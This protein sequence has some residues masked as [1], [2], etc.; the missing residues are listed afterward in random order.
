MSGTTQKS[1]IEVIGTKTLNGSSNR[2]MIN[3]VNKS[4]GGRGIKRLRS[5]SPR[6]GR[7]KSPPIKRIGSTTIPRMLITTDRDAYKRRILITNIPYD[8]KWDDLKKFVNDQINEDPFVCVFH[9]TQGK[10]KGMAV[11]EFKS[12]DVVP[13]AVKQLNK[14]NFKGRDINVREET[15]EARDELGQPRKM[16]Q[17]TQQQ[18][19]NNQMMN[20]N[21]MNSNM[22]DSNFA[23]NQT[24]GIVP[25]LLAT[26]EIQPPL[27]RRV[28][29]ANLDYNVTEKEL[30]EGFSLAGR[31]V[32]IEILKS[33]EGKSRGQA[34]LEYSHPV[35]AVQAISMFRG[36]QFCGRE[37]S[38]RMDDRKTD[39]VL[40]KP[41][42]TVEKLPSQ[43]T[44]V[45]MGLGDSGR[46]LDYP[47]QLMDMA[48][49]TYV[50][51][52]SNTGNM[53]NQTQ[54]NMVASTNQAVAMQPTAGGV[55]TFMPMSTSFVPSQITQQQVNAQAI[56]QQQQPAAAPQQQQFINTAQNMITTP[57]AMSGGTAG[58]L[59]RN[60]SQNAQIANTVSQ[61]EQ[62][63]LMG[64]QQTGQQMVMGAD[65]NSV[66]QTGVAAVPQYNM[67][68]A[69]SSMPQMMLTSQAGNIQTTNSFTD[70]QNT[71]MPQQQQQSQQNQLQQQQQ[72]MMNNS[73][74]MYSEGGW[75][76]SAQ[77]NEMQGSGMMQMGGANSAGF[78][79]FVKNLPFNTS[80]NS[81]LEH[82]AGYIGNDSI[83][84]I[85]ML[86]NGS[87][88]VVKV[89]TQKAMKY[90]LDNI[91]GTM[92]FKRRMD[93][94]IDKTME[95]FASGGGY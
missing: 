23:P 29:I 70:F 55:A 89:K 52:M 41:Y 15:A 88:A 84:E 10:S 73:Q 60:P 1:N 72:M 5:D 64:F 65:Q 58:Q 93:V 90:A 6:L 25:K 38:I 85:H 21:M 80:R 49:G 2:R 8:A 19:H 66:Q 83:N 32:T 43:W 16:G 87:C 51:N 17:H 67:M 82:F 24:F 79:L 78:A 92:F 36:A 31:V 53:M 76:M 63:Q 45:G 71:G 57:I 14:Q 4:Q 46:P 95:N 69:N 61:Q 81:L 47:D 30:L 42:P 91:N 3:R 20:S 86:K 94:L 11:A 13:R 39:A 50:P 33:P 77:M 54:Q 68:Q 26:L 7:S 34:F 44:S 18:I 40:R 22:Y 28:F 9:D 62:Q 12:P 48:M 75:D 56:Q 59:I 37:L 74:M 35:E 27:S